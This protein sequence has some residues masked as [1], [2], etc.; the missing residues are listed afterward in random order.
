[1]AR[2]VFLGTPEFGVPVLEA[3]AA[4][5]E[6][7]A[8]VTQPDRY[9]GRGRKRI[10]APPVKVKALE[11]EL[12]VLQPARL[13]R[14]REVKA[15]LSAL[16]ADLFVIAAYGQIL[17]PDVLAM[18]AHGCIGVHASLLPRWRGAAPIAAAILHGDART[19]ISLMLT[20]KGMDTGPVIAQARLDIASDDTT[21]TLSVRLAD[22]G[23]E[24]LIESIPSWLAGGI[25]AQPQDESLVTCAPPFIKVQGAINW[26]HS[27]MAIDHQ[28][29]AMTPWP[30]A[31][32]GCEHGGLRVLEAH[33]LLEWR[34]EQEP[35]YVVEL[36]G[37]IGVVTGK[38]LLLLDRVQ[39]AGKRAMDARQFALGRQG[40][41][42][43]VLE[44]LNCD[45]GDSEGADGI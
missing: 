3:L 5:H 32:C 21:E 31:F 12:P 9:A 40:F 1:M 45:E 28:I 25:E 11:L 13:R 22:L 33:P 14:D 10:V 20:D 30:G 17:R 24:L 43:S 29:R 36:S 8:V 38:G 18:P 19:G 2:I 44:S 16:G 41:V 26:H 4:H 15:T 7:L 6:V 27:A 35:G 39:L 42:C 37:E 34:G 23:A